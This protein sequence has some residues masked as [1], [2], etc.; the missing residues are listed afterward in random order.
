MPRRVFSV[1]RRYRG[2]GVWE[3]FEESKM[4]GVIPQ[5]NA[6]AEASPESLSELMSRDPEGY[7]SQDIKR[8]V[9]ELRAQR[10]RWA[11][12]EGEKPGGSAKAK[13]TPKA[14]T[15]ILKQSPKTLDELF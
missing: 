5:S 8:I 1:E 10:E 9:A 15:E 13:T 12:A 14:I 3:R 2:A 7:Q 11:R 6:L 4:T